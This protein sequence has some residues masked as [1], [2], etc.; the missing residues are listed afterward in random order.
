MRFYE[1]E[2]RY[3]TTEMVA[4]MDVVKVDNP[5][6]LSKL[7]ALGFDCAEFDNECYFLATPKFKQVLTLLENN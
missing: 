2:L 4:Q 6:T 7:V 3:Y 1:D 5:Y